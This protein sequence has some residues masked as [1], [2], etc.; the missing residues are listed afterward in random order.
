[1]MKPP[2]QKMV[3]F[4]G[5]NKCKVAYRGNDQVMYLWID[6]GNLTKN[7]PGAGLEIWGN[8]QQV[9]EKVNGVVL[10]FYPRAE[11]ASQS[12]NRTV[13]YRVGN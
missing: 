7:K 6:Y 11:I 13:V 4:L 9:F 5:K 8:A 12:G 10:R 3:E 2:N 1:M